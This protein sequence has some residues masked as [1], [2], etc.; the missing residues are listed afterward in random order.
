VAIFELGVIAL[1]K[2][3]TLSAGLLAH[4]KDLKV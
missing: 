4:G 1:K 2:F 3:N